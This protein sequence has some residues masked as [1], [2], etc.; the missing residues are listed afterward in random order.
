LTTLKYVDS[1]HAY[2]LNG[3]R[4]KGVSTCAKIGTDTYALEKWQ[5]RQVLLGVAADPSLLLSVDDPLYGVVVK[6][7][8]EIVTM[9]ERRR[10]DDLVERALEAAGAYEA[11]RAGTATH[12]LTDRH[13]AGEID[14]DALLP[15]EKESLRKW[16]HA[17]ERAGFRRIPGM[18]ERVIVYPEL[19][20]CGRFDRI[21]E[22]VSDGRPVGIDLK[23]GESAVRYPHSTVAQV[24]MYVNAPVMADFG[25]EDAE[26]T[27]KYEKTS[28]FL[29]MPADIDKE[30]GYVIH[31][32]AE[33][34]FA[35]VHAVNLR[36]GWQ[37]CEKV[38]FPALRWRDI[39]NEKLIREIV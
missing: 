9:D 15:H 4:C 11:A 2:Y 14:H 36:L 37:A 38:I 7:D 12:D 28:T 6:E 29:P 17:I 27:E 31:M 26:V 25:A 18:A 10:H 1:N 24:A 39:P 30:I 20:L 5:Q 13:D 35:T 23:T 33:E 19:R 3:K 34:P 16:D 32:P 21:F 22:R 8:G